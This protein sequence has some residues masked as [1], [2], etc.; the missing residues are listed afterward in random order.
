MTGY[1]F[2]EIQ[3][4]NSILDGKSVVISLIIDIVNFW[5]RNKNMWFSHKEI[6]YF[7][8]IHLIYED[9]KNI[10][11]AL[12]LQYDQIFRHPCKL[13]KDEDRPKAFDFATKLAFKMIQNGQYREMDD[14][15]KVFTLLSIR[16]NNNL[17]FKQI[18]LNMAFEQLNNKDVINKNIWIRF[19]NASIIDIDK[20]KNSLGHKK[21]ILQNI[22]TIIDFEYLRVIFKDILEEPTK[23]DPSLILSRHKIF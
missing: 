16:H 22:D 17:T 3:D 18:A 9:C 21:E 8:T 15:E 11:I 12:L 4:F 2:H 19:I 1:S 14:C 7:P 5:K 20:L 13:I 6:V 10:N 23:V